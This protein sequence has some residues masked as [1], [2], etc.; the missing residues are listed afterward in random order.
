MTVVPTPDFS[1]KAVKKRLFEIATLTVPDLRVDGRWRPPREQVELL[2]G[3]V[4]DIAKARAELEEMA[5]YMQASY[6]ELED[7]WDAIEGWQTAMPA[8]EKTQKAI[9]A[10][11]RTISPEIY[12]GIRE[13]KWLADKLL[14][15]VRR[16]ERDEEWT[17]SRLYTMITGG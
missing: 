2:E 11:K 3:H 15:Q 9:T 13:G 4:L 16:L 14:R 5:L 8:G 1:P 17:C 12:D 6:K 10:A 7:Q